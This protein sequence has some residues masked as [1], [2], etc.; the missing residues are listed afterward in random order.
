MFNYNTKAILYYDNNFSKSDNGGMDLKYNISEK[1]SL[2]PH[3]KQIYH[4]IE[5]NYDTLKILNAIE[6][7][8]DK[9][10]P[11]TKFSLELCD[12][13]GW[14]TETK[15]LLNVHVN[16]EMFFNGMLDHFNEIYAEIE[17]IIRDIENTVVLFPELDN[18]NSIK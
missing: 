6:P 13:L 4:F 18:K 11:D 10:F 1:F 3:E 14:T 7:L 8:L 15:L 16:D 12:N 5:N 2:D 9:Q 17:P